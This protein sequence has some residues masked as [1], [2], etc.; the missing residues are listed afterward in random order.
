M[1]IDKYELEPNSIIYNRKEPLLSYLCQSNCLTIPNG[2]LN[3]QDQQDEVLHLVIDL[4]PHAK[5]FHYLPGQSVGVIVPHKENTQAKPHKLRLYSISSANQGDDGSGQTLSLCVRRVIERD[6]QNQITF[7]GLASNYLCDLKQGDPLQLSGPVGKAFVLP[8]DD[9]LN[10]LLFAT[11]T[12]IAPFRSF[13]NFIYKEK[14]KPS[15]WRGK[16]VLF[17]GAKNKSELLYLNAANQDLKDYEKEGV[18]I[19]TACSR[20]EKNLQGKRLYVQDLA[21]M[22]KQEI[23]DLLKD[24]HCSIYI[25]GVKGMKKGIEESLEKI[26]SPNQQ[27]NHLPQ[28][29]SQSEWQQR[30]AKLRAEGKWNIEVY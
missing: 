15:G 18:H 10:L 14:Q 1:K 9:S 21:L 16:I 30:K 29:T 24:D 5:H 17:M 28:E 3:E 12:G 13:L 23:L 8:K 6:A 2:Q 25:C 7:R 4:G 20:E 19:Y 26:Y 11:G 27:Q 22:H